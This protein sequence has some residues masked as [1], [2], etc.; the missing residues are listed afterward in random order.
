[1]PDLYT[2][3]ELPNVLPLTLRQVK[4]LR[5]AN[6]IPYVRLNRYTRLYSVKK[7]VAA[8]QRLETTAKGPTAGD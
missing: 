6:L 4:N 3:T 2:E 1:M 8:L 5:R 7:V